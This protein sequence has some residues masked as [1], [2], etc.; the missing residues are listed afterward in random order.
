[1]CPDNQA[2]PRRRLEEMGIAYS[3]KKF[4]QY[5]AGGDVPVVDLFLESGIRVTARTADGKSALFLATIEGHT[6]IAKQL[7]HRGADPLEAVHA[8][9]RIASKKK[10]V[11]DKLSALASVATILSSLLIALVGGWFTYSYNKRQI[12]QAAL[13]SARDNALK[14]QQNRVAELDTI[15]KLVPYLSKDEDSK[16]VAL[17]AINALATPQV[18]TQM[19][20]LYQGKG[21]VCALEKIATVGDQQAKQQAVSALSSIASSTRADD[22]SQAIGAL[23]GI[24]ERYKSGVVK[25]TVTTDQGE[26][27][28]S[29]LV[30]SGS[31]L[32]L[33]PDYMAGAHFAGGPVVN[34][35]GFQVEL[36]DGTKQPAALI[37]VSEPYKLALLKVTNAHVFPIALSSVLPTAG[38]P[39]VMVGFLQGGE[40][41]AAVGT[42]A[43]VDASFVKVYG[44]GEAAGGGGGPIL[45]DKGEA[46]GILH[47][48][49][50]GPQG[51]QLFVRS[52]LAI[53]YLQ[54]K[55]LL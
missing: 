50:S 28:S 41:R 3:E 47:S 23:S 31:G 35:K 15:Q 17:L 21:S 36:F 10:D 1:M 46:I 44:I 29:G 51:L 7:L 26:A 9:H 32:V 19:A 14:E 25:V 43:S 24:F 40:L 33:I 34:A 16:C 4:L 39:V 22:R 8:V 48:A 2:D 53:K 5:V 49:Q 45:N 18:A 38:T 52:D 6:E 13:Q 37:D 30:V 42:V 27:S 54:S 55:R 20:R 11:W 12:E